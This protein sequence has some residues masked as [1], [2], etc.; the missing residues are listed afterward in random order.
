[1]TY[2]ED[3]REQKGYFGQHDIF[4]GIRNLFEGITVCHPVYSTSKSR[5]IFVPIA[6][7]SDGNTCISVYDP[8]AST[9]NEGRLCLDCG[10]TKLYINWDAAGTAR[11]I[12]NASCWLLRIENHFK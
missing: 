4:T 9:S 11:Y 10:F 8:P 1:M 7:A 3:G 2:K 6:T 12:V 5:K